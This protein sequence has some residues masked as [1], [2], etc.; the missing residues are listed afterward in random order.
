[1]KLDKMNLENPKL[2]TSSFIFA[3][4]A[5]LLTGVAFYQISVTLPFYILEHFHVDKAHMSYIL[6]SYVLAALFIRFFSGY[7]VDNFSRKKVYLLSFIAFVALFFGYTI[8]TSI[9]FLFVLRI[10]HGLAWGVITTS[11]NT[12]AIDLLPSKKRGEGI[13]YYGLMSTLAMSVGPICGMYIYENYPFSYIFYSALL[14]G[15]IGII[16]VI[17]IKDPNKHKAIQPGKRVSTPITLDRF[18]LIYAIPLAFNVLLL[19][20]TYG[21]LY[22]FGVMY[23]KEINILG[24]SYMFLSIAFGIG[25][26]RVF[27]GKLIDKGWINQVN[28][29]G[30]LLISLGYLFIAYP[31]FHWFYFFGAFLIGV[32]FGISIPAFQ[33]QFMNMTVPEKRGS[34]NSTFFI[35]IDLGLGIGM[36]L[37]GTLVNKYGFQLLFA[38]SAALCFLSVIYYYFNSTKTYEKYKRIP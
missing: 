24:A 38:L 28:L 3:C 37:S 20:I 1:M 15:T 5:N 16:C 30:I 33:T 18:I 14:F 2:W 34:A 26:S 9:V 23:G 7:L 8:A 12:L 36:V 22:T 25:I 6:S 19:E 27:S 13:G 11:S 35:A 17:F 10:F 32:G 31:L 21:A 4:F 29:I